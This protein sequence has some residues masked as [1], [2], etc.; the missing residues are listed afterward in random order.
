[1]KRPGKIHLAC[2]VIGLGLIISLAPS[3]ALANEP[4]KQ[5]IRSNALLEEVYG[6]NPQAALHL[7]EELRV[8]LVAAENGKL[9]RARTSEPRFRRRGGSDTQT[10]QP[11]SEIERQHREVLETN[12]ALRKLLFHSPVAYLRLLKRIR[13]AAAGAGGKAAAQ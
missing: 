13:Q 5:L 6:K 12:P 9:Q 3:G 4:A 7:A 2:V 8:S 11:Q 10:G 1:M